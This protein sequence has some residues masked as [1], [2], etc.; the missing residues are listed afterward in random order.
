MGVLAVVVAGQ[1]GPGG[2]EGEIR[3]GVGRRGG[4]KRGGGIGTER[5]DGLGMRV[6]V[7]ISNLTH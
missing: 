2:V 6:G 1:I 3:N 5:Y 7:L 4:A